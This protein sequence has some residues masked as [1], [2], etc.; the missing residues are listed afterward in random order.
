MTVI[1]I[2][3]PPRPLRKLGEAQRRNLEAAADFH[4]RAIRAHADDAN[5]WGMRAGWHGGLRVGLQLGA[6]AG[7]L[8][9]ICLTLAAAGAGWLQ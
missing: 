4:T 3:T 9:G 8:I 1:D 5:A 2:R 6:L 7:C